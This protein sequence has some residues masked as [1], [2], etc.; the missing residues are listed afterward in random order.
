MNSYNAL[1]EQYKNN[2]QELYTADEIQSILNLALEKL[3]G[4]NALT[5]RMQKEIS[6]ETFNRALEIGNELQ[7]GKPIQYILGEASFYGLTLQVNEHVLI[8]RMETEELVNLI[9]KNHKAEQNLEIIDIGTGSGCIPIA[10]AK[11]LHYKEITAA[12]ISSDAI[13]LAKQNASDNQVA[14]HFK[15]IDILEWDLVFDAEQYDLIVSNPP[16]IRNMEKA[17]MHKN[18]LAYEPHL[19]LFVEDHTPLLFYTTIADFALQHLKKS[20]KLYFEINQYLGTETQDMLLK[21]GFKNVLIL[22]DINGAQ[23]MIVADR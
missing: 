2:L 15:E 21:K 3:T 9:I 16:Y 17:A 7:Q 22:N 20:G 14:I 12:D 11:H 13:R 18:V 23:R 19:A 10:L 8:P 5:V 6:S 1:S 4:K